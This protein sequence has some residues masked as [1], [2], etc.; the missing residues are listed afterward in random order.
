MTEFKRDGSEYRSLTNH[1][2][3]SGLG[4]ALEVASRPS[5]GGQAVFRFRMTDGTEHESE[6]MRA[7]DALRRSEVFPIIERYWRYWPETDSWELR[8]TREGG[9]Q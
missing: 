1:L 5:F 2:M 4:D 3:A 8:W 7:I 9:L 6:P